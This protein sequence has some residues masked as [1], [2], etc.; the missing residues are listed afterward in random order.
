MFEEEISFRGTDLEKNGERRG[1][2]EIEREIE[3]KKEEAFIIN[4]RVV[5][6]CETRDYYIVSSLLEPSPRW[7]GRKKNYLCSCRPV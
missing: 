3:R 6:R 1:E 5:L 4:N 7:G 2:I